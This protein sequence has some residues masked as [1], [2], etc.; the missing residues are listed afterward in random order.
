MA[1]TTA[2]KPRPRRTTPAKP[3]PRRRA[4]AKR[5]TDAQ[6]G[7][8]LALL[9]D[10]DSTELKVTIPQP[11][12]RATLLALGLDPLD[13]Q[14]RVVYFFDTPELALEKAG[15][16]VRGRRIQGKGDDTV[17]KL[18]PVVPDKLPA[19]LRESPSFVVEVDALP[20]GYVCSGSFKGIPRK[21][22]VL[23]VALGEA[24]I[25]RIFSK[26][27]R[28]FYAE[29]APAGIA[30]DDLITIGPVFVLKLKGTPKGAARKFA[31][32]LWLYPDGRILELSTRCRPDQAVQVAAET[33]AFL[34]ERGVDM[35]GKQQT[36]TRS[37]LEYF[38]AHPD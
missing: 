18:R 3:R 34:A 36:K 4:A 11:E 13:V 10:V 33:R 16:V 21:A 30:L 25:R 22:S 17:V 32:E 7:E 27:Q 14:V 19:E 37:A 5:L 24:P 28:A 38:V 9:R 2:A 15:I 35:G 1:T 26:E 20:G 23:D 8:L 12:Q 6:L 29:H 31:V